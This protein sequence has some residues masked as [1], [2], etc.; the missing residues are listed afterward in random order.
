MRSTFQEKLDGQNSSSGD[1]RTASHASDESRGAR[2]SADVPLVVDLDGTLLRTDLLHECTLRLLKK[3]P[4][5]LFSLPLWLLRG[6]SHLKRSVFGQAS[7]DTSVLPFDPQVLAWLREEKQSGRCLVLATASDRDLAEQSVKDLGLFDV[8]LGS[9]P[10]RDLRGADK[11]VAIR[12]HCGPNFDYAGNAWA[13]V[14]IWRVS[15]AAILVNTGK[16]LETRIR[17]SAKVS[18]SISSQQNSLRATI[19]SLRL[20]Q[21][22]KNLL[23]LVPVFTSHQWGN[24][25]VLVKSAIAFL[26]FG[27]CASGTYIINDLLDLEEDRRHPAKKSRPFSSGECSIRRGVIVGGACLATGLV[28]G[29]F[30]GNG[31]LPML[32]LY[33]VLTACYSLRLKKIFLLD[34][35]TLALLYTLRVVTG[36]VITGIAFSMWLL[37]F[38]FFLFLSLAFSKRAA[39]LIALAR[40]EEQIVPGRGYLVADLQLVTVA[41][42]CSGFLSSLVFALYVN[43]MSVTLLYRRPAILWGIL[44]LLLYYILRV[45]IICGRGQL[46]VDPILYTAKSKSTYIIGFMILLLVMAATFRF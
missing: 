31:L 37:S 8:V 18:R 35:F 38:S 17:R 15:R 21:W 25:P 14:A 44:P 9:T 10:T 20:Y 41:G 16:T 6:R 12:E 2:S 19:K 22:V 5:M 1:G 40:G 42:I 11:A 45:W 13:D 26:A 39:E 34:V 3:K 29:F 27:F 7:L 36:H 46:D 33:V 23:I 24:A 43:S 30:A 32:L 28:I 4:W